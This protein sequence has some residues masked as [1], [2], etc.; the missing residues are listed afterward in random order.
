VNVRTLRRL[1]REALVKAAIVYSGYAL[2]WTVQWVT[3]LNT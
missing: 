2:H 1:A 3:W